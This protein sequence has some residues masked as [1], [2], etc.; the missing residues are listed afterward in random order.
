M[1][2]G[3]TKS[4]CS[5]SLRDVAK[6]RA[7]DQVVITSRTIMGARAVAASLQAE[8]GAGVRVQ[9]RISLQGPSSLTLQ[10][11]LLARLATSPQVVR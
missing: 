3:T 11:L 2:W 7:G 1:M 5:L 10:T 9:A 8:V 6:R 4:S